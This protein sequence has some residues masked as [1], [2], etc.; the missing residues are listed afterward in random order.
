MPKVL[1]IGLDGATWRLFEPWARTGRMPHLAALMARGTWGPLRSTVPAL[2]LPA[3]SSFM[4]GRNPGAHGVFAFR[5]H[6]PDR[7]QPG[8]LANASDLRAATLWE[9]AGRAGQRVGVINVP[10]S[11]PIRPVNGFVVSCMLT[12]PGE[13][14]TDPPEVAAELGNYRIDLPVPSN[15]RVGAPDYRTNALTYLEG[16]REQ[17]RW[18]GE[19]TVRLME[20]RPVD[21]LCVVF[22]APDRV[23]HY[24]WQFANGAG[25]DA[26]DAPILEAVEAVY[27]TLD[28]A[29]GRLVAASGPDATVVVL[30]DH[31]FDDRPERAVHINRWLADQGLLRRRPL[32]RL[33][34]KVIR[35]MFPTPWRT[36]Y[37]TLDHILL[38]RA[39]SRAWSETIFTGTAGI[40]VH[41]AGRYP[42]GCVAPGPEYEAV[43][44]RIQTGLRALQDEE[45]RPVFRSVERRE[46]LYRGPYVEEAPD[47]VAVCEQRFGIVFESLRRDLRERSL[48]GPYHEMGYTGTH[49]PDGIYLFAGPPVRALG[50]HQSYPIESIAPTVLH[51]LGLPVPSSMEG[52]VCSSVLTEDFQRRQPVRVSTAESEVFTEAGGWRS[53][54]DE[55]KV[56]DHLRALGYLE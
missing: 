17:T 55:A 26:A 37:D 49:D 29:V 30:S 34:R 51:L 15:L 10:P 2:T 19:A 16:M 48:F 4:T 35:K 31:G 13:P 12:P 3:W 1:I 44:T 41:V 47:L 9:I 43:R 56:A 8:G 24:F 18:R 42:L 6:P 14:F 11:Y 5:R 7:Y 38:D 28:E 52:P 45:G 20:R 22:Y 32:W 53:E 21:L 36:R 23:Q 54:A 39:K 27:R 40:W 33:R 25:R 46:D 50:A